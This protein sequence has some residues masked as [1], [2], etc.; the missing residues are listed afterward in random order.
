MKFN[1]SMDVNN[2]E[3]KEENGHS[4]FLEGWLTFKTF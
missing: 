4:T 3:G 1:G 2:L